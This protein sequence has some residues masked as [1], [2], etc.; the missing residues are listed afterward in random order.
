LKDYGLDASAILAVLNQ[1]TG[2]H[3]V[4]GILA[5]SCA[6]AANIAEVYGKLAEEGFSEREAEGLIDALANDI[7]PLDAQ[8]A[9]LP[10]ALLGD[11]F[12]YH[13]CGQ[14]RWPDAEPRD[15]SG[16]AIPRPP[17]PNLRPTK[18]PSATSPAGPDPAGPQQTTAEFADC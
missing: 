18:G 11:I 12:A 16:N 6:C 14:A 8:L 9:R 1:E 15:D 7:L 10:F 13:A 2:T 5:D 4:E 17:T 3:W